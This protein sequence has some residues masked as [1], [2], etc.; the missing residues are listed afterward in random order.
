MFT[1][2][3]TIESSFYRET[4]LSLKLF[5]LMLRLIYIKR[6]R[7]IDQA[8]YHLCGENSND[9]IGNRRRFSRTSYG[10]CHDGKK[11]MKLSILPPFGYK[12]E[13]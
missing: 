1:D 6:N 9:S 4:M 5:G 7:R 3:T 2:K 10:R 8:V 11:N 13:S 12:C